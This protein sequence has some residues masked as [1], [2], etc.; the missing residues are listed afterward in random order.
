MADCM[1]FRDVGQTLLRYE[2]EC[3]GANGNYGAL[4][5]DRRDAKAFAE[6]PQ[7]RR[8]HR[9]LQEDRV[10]ETRA[11][12][13][14]GKPA[15]KRQKAASEVPAKHEEGVSGGKTAVEETPPTLAELGDLQKDDVLRKLV[16]KLEGRA[17]TLAANLKLEANQK[18]DGE[19]QQA[20]GLHLTAQWVTKR[21][22]RIRLGIM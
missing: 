14:P 22:N 2:A 15:Q 19:A 11:A 17:S 20:S 5:V 3:R 7:R 6:E 9:G 13:T 21:A 4:G 8:Q 18:V 16:E 10:E 1:G 12:K